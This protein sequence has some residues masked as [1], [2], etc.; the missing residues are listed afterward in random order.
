MAPRWIV[1]IALGVIALL[2]FLLLPEAERPPEKTEIEGASVRESPAPARPRS[3]G[4]APEPAPELEPEPGP[5]SPL[6]PGEP[7]GER[8]ITGVGLDLEGRP[9]ADA[10]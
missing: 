9:I 6:E 2:A 3:S 8:A 1:L 4:E 10:I 7:P 5:E